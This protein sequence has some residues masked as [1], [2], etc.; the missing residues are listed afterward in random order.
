MV[1]RLLK[2]CGLASLLWVA[3]CSSGAQDQPAP[4]PGARAASPV[5]AGSSVSAEH[6]AGAAGSPS[7]AGGGGDGTAKIAA[8][9]QAD[10]AKAV[11]DAAAHPALTRS[12][13][14]AAPDDTLMLYYANDP[15][16][17]NP[18]TSSDTTSDS[19]QRWV[20][21][22]LADTDMSNPDLFK[23]ALAERWDF[24]EKTLTFKIYLRKKVKWHPMTLPNGEEL[25]AKEVTSRDVKFTFDCILNKN[26]D[27]AAIRSYYEDEEAKDE[28]Q[29]I[30]IKVTVIDDYTVQIQWTKPYFQI[31]EFTLGIPIIPRHVYSVDKNGKPISF[32]F[33]SKEFAEG[34]NNHWANRQ[35]CG[36]GPMIYKAWKKDQRFELVRNPDYW[37]EPFYFSKVVFQNIPNSK[38]S[39]DLLL[40]NDL[41][42]GS[43][44]EKDRFVQSR[45]HPAV[46]A[47][48][49]KLVEYPY[50][51]YRYI[52]YNLKRGEFLKEK[53]VR[54]ALSHAIPLD[55]IIHEVYKDLAVRTTGHF[56]PGSSAYDA[57]IPF[58]PYDLEKSRTLLEG[59]GWRDTDKDG[60]RD[61][62]VN[63]VK[64]PAR[65]DLMIP[66]DAPQFLTVA[67]IFKD[68]C[69]KIGVD[70]QIS[71]A[72]WALMLQRLRKKEFDAC[73]LGWALS[74]KG[75]PYQIWHS[76]QAD[77]PESSNSIGYKNPE[78]DKLIETLRVTLNE[79][80]Q[81]QLYHKMHRLIYDDQPYTFLFV[82]L[83]TGVQHSRL[84]NVK[85]YKVRPCID[86]HEWYAS[87]P[88]QEGK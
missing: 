49:V 6:T 22:P 79:E 57:S 84:Q 41:D 72:K 35:M 25:P 51:A 18:I 80:Q 65:F 83:A 46:K 73:M 4:A 40:Q 82:D 29:R 27:A 70:V 76:S 59:A 44:A 23:P 8:A 87:F 36:T 88:R 48:K 62:L 21:E 39:S 10:H 26:I 60:I 78:L 55:T 14:A 1:V 56:L 47:G 9:Q 50:P 11:A 86:Q 42:W 32:D 16:T 85:F 3:G 15:D 67:E 33:S 38:T 28:S 69:R 37:G 7:P 68:N 12:G 19:F 75:D 17:V 64:V 71:S 63:N 52:G 24:D 13:K 34:F 30:K 2:C 20:Y 31:R 66:S 61:K 77:T 74:W 58:I 45:E 5:S 53:S 43:I 81:A 54:W